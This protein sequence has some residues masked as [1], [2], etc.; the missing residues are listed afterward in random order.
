MIGDEQQQILK[1]IAEAFAVPRPDWFCDA[2]HCCECA[3]HE[4]TLQQTAVESLD[5]AIVC[6]GA[7]NPIT[8]IKN[9]QGF[10]YFMPALARLAYGTGQD[11][12][13]DLFLFHL[14]YD[15]I[16]AFSPRQRTAVESLLV[17][18]AIALAPEIERCRHW[19]ELEWAF[20]R[21]RGEPGPGT[22]L[23]TV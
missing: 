16:A 9:P 12:N 22:Y 14:R 3:E 4:L 20:R 5:Y 17:H 18:L 10:A 19:P 11:Y 8:M 7:W 23:G 2:R 21:A 13:L 1:E 6:N 15:R